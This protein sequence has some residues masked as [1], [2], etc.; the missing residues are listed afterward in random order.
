[1]THAEA[2]DWAEYMRKRGT[3]NVGVRIE[4]GFALLATMIMKRTG[5]NAKLTD[6]LTAAGEEE[7]EGNA[8]ID[9]VMGILTGAKA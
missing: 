1:M 9:D 2:V 4:L 5:G 7:D 8:T 3:L 6:F